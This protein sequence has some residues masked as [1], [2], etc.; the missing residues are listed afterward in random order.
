MVLR[1]PA[2]YG[3]TSTMLPF[4]G[5]VSACGGGCRRN[6]RHC[7][8]FYVYIDRTPA[9]ITARIEIATGNSPVKTQQ[10]VSTA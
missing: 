4:S 9:F 8:A 5:C 2:L 1:E 3:C 6:V 10:P 7:I